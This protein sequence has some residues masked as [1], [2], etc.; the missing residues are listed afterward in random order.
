MGDYLK[1]AAIRYRDREAIFC[2]STGRR[3][4]FLELNRRTNQLANGLMAMGLKKG[5]AADVRIVDAEGKD[6]STGAIG[7]IIGRVF[8]KC[9]KNKARI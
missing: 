1:V 2:A 5:D 6:V 8:Q 9:G 3:F 7:D 4:T